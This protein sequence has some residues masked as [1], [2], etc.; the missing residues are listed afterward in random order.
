MVV[1][2]VV[3]L[4]DFVE[5][6]DDAFLGDFSIKFGGDVVITLIIISSN[7]V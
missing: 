4:D 1:V 6:A 2:Y 5:V 3:E 7:V